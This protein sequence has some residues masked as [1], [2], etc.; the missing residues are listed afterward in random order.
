MR[1]MKEN[2]KVIEKLR[3]KAEFY[4]LY[5]KMFIET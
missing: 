4:T 1:N 5:V 3:C 2:S